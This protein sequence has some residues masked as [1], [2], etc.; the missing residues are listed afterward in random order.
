MPRF[1]FRVLMGI[2]EGSASASEIENSASALAKSPKQKSNLDVHLYKLLQVASLLLMGVLRLH[3][4]VFHHSRR[5]RSFGRFRIGFRAGPNFF[6]IRKN[7]DHFRQNRSGEKK[8]ELKHIFSFQ[9][10]IDH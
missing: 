2:A 3:L 4:E 5:R 1:L 9:D 10:K 8:A 6:E 7:R